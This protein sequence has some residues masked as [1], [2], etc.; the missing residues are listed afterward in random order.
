MEGVANAV[1]NFAKQRLELDVGVVSPPRIIRNARTADTA[2]VY[3]EIHDY[4]N[5]STMRKLV[6]NH[7]SFVPG[8]MSKIKEAKKSVGAQRCSRCH[9]W[10]HAVKFNGKGCPVSMYQ[11]CPLCDGPHMEHNHRR[12]AAC[13][14]SKP[15]ANPPTKGTPEGEPCPHTAR[16]V[17]CRGNHPSNSVKCLFWIHRF[18]PEWHQR[19]YAKAFAEHLAGKAEAAARR[20]TTVG[21]AIANTEAFTGK[22]LR[23]KGEEEANRAQEGQ[24]ETPAEG[25]PPSSTS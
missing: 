7:I 15:K 9:R 5:G 6:G 21:G 22:V 17:N 13:C 18:H 24:R 2:T 12:Y 14:Q 25:S 4:K 19:R 1:V 23:G 3:M 16:C 10:G 8:Q 11:R 20:K